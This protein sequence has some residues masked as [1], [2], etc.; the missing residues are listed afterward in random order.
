MLRTV[1]VVVAFS[2]LWV[3]L[4]W[5]FEPLIVLCGA[6]S[7]AATVAIMRRLDLMDREGAPFELTLRVLVFIPWLVR[8][9]VMAN[10]QMA[11]VVL[12]PRLRIQPHL[13]RVPAS[14]RTPVGLAIHAN[15]IT[16]TPGTISLDVRDGTILV[17]ALTE[18]AASEDGSGD[19]DR[20]ISWVEGR[21]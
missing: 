8:E 16:I 6:V 20:K 9:I 11:R 17:H 18:A 21:L 4:S 14:Q 1:V 10:L 15:T 19:I 2:V 13:I 12:S 3:L 5:H 7:V